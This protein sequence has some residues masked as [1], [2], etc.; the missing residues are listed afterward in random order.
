MVG[1]VTVVAGL[2]TTQTIAWASSYCMP[3]ILGAPIATTLHFPTSVFFGLFSGAPLLSAAADRQVKS[4]R[5]TS[6]AWL[7]VSC[8]TSSAICACNSIR[9]SGLLRC[10]ATQ[11]NAWETS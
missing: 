10:V 7:P 1:S 9:F 6:A 5:C 3:A 4:G 2:G 8:S 11:D